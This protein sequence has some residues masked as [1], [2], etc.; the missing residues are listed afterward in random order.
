MKKQ[1][2]LIVFALPL[3]GLLGGCALLGLGPRQARITAQ[4][5]LP[6]GADALVRFEQGRAALDTGQNAA[7]VAAFSEARLEPALLG[8]SLNGMAVAYARLGRLDLAERYFNQAVA[9][10]P[11]EAR[12]AANLARL[13]ETLRA[14]DE[15][16][17][18]AAA[19]PAPAAEPAPT[20]QAGNGTVRL[21]TQG[22]GLAR[23]ASA[24]TTNRF[25][26]INPAQV[27]LSR[28][29]TE[30]PRNGAQDRT[31]IDASAAQV[32]ASTVPDRQAYPI[33]VSFRQ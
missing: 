13:Q 31:R 27:Q 3:A 19:A 28:T 23:V 8:P 20:I 1:I 9:A 25:V 18:L 2:A 12:F 14:V 7:A 24:P 5:T 11:Q 21:V 10:A 30:T 6:M 26:R 15:R 29:L 17:A 4:S 33:R 22:G 32:A 16:P